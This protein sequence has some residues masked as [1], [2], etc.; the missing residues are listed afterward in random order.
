MAQGM[1]TFD[2]LNLR[3]VLYVCERMR[4]ADWA[5]IVNLLPRSIET[6]DMIA[7]VTMQSSRFGVIGKLDGEPIVVL[8]FGELLDGTWRAGLFATDKFD[9]IG[10]ATVRHIL[11]VTVP[12]LLDSG[13]VYCDALAD[14]LNDAGVAMLEFI[15]FKKRAI[16]PEYGS[17]GRDIALYVATKKEIEHVL[18]RRRRRNTVE[19]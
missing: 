11:D 4:A 3:D 14:P 12:F 13:A 15:G 2:T 1:I 7:M 10:K 5:E 6:A 19:R 17:R 18:I 16:L 9:R 8:Q